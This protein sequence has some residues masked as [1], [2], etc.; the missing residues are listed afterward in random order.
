MF[1]AAPGRSATCHCDLCL[2]EAGFSDPLA[3]DAAP[4]PPRS[5]HMMDVDSG[6]R[7]RASPELVSSVFSFQTKRNDP[8][9]VD[10]LYR[11]IF[12]DSETE[13]LKGGACQVE[14]CL[15]TRLVFLPFNLFFILFPKKMKAPGYGFGKKYTGRIIVII[16]HSLHISYI[17]ICI[18]Y[19]S[20]MLVLRE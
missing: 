6:R 19:Q 9:W 13:N 14:Q 20:I 5:I 8:K 12:G 10:R 11:A 18:M 3:P 16:Y 17:M 7:L 15:C 4:V 2:L 1:Q